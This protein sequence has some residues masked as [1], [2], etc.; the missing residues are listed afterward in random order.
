MLYTRLNDAGTG[1]EPQRDLLKASSGLD[2][3]GSVAADGDGNVYAAWHGNAPGARGEGDRRIWLARSTD[4][5]RTFASEKPVNP[6]PTG[7]CAC[8]SLKAFAEPAGP[9]YVLYRTATEKVNRDMVL[10]SSTTGSDRFRG[11]LVQRWKVPG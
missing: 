8:C 4:D 5:G 11:A 7:A 6:A 1:F 3:G 9:V 10:L 2:G